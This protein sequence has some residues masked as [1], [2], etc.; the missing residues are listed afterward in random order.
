MPCTVGGSRIC[1]T[2]RAT[3]TTPLR[4]S[5]PSSNSTCTISSIKNGL[6]SVR[7]ITMRLSGSSSPPSPNSVDSISPALSR[8]SASSRNCA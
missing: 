6:P 5:A 4:T 7:S 2:G 3:F 1:P 8:P